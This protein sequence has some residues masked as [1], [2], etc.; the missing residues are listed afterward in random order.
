MNVDRRHLAL[1][2]LA[3][4]VLAAAPAL[5]PSVFAPS[6]FASAPDEATVTE[7]RSASRRADGG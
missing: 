1:P 6:A 5:A 3:F 2:A 7:D 4:G